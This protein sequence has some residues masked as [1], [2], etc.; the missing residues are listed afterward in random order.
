[1][2]FIW[3]TLKDKIA[4]FKEKHQGIAAAVALSMISE[5]LSFLGSFGQGLTHSH[6]MTPVDAPGKQAFWKHCG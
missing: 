1:M 2:L 3:T 4:V 5:K 6:T